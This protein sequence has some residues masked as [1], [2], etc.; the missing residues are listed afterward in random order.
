MCSRGCLGPG[1]ITAP[2]TYVSFIYFYRSIF[3]LIIFSFVHFANFKKS[4]EINI[5]EP[6]GAVYV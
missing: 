6:L 4:K 1:S 2:G 3:Q 5:S